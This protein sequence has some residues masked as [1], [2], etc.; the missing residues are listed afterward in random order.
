M[1]CADCRGYFMMTYRVP[2]VSSFYCGQ[3]DGDLW[4]CG[5]GVTLA[6]DP[7]NS[8]EMAIEGEMDRLTRKREYN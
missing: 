1:R 8:A 6:L 3:C 2:P 5:P 4:P 7:K